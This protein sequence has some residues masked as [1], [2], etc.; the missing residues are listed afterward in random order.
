[1]RQVILL[2]SLVLGLGVFVSGNA[3]AA[4]GGR[5][6]PF[7]ASGSGSTT[8]DLLSGEGHSVGT[9]T[10]THC[11]ANGDQV[12]LDGE[13]PPSPPT[14]SISRFWVSTH[15]PEVPAASRTRA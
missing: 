10:A 14:V 11:G 5:N 3:L 13:A 6:L 15:R 12:T 7:S 4:R 8:I 1:M 9:G 2:A